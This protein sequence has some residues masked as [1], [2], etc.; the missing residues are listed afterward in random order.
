MSFRITGLAPETFVPLFTMDDAALA[1][2]GAC[3]RFADAPRGY[4]C[5]VSL[6]DAAP[7]EELVLVNYEHQPAP[8]PYR[9][10]HAIYVRRDAGSRFD[11]I[12][13]LPPVF[14]GRTLSLR[15]FDSTHMI[16]AASL[17]SG[18]DA[19]SAI[20]SLLAFR[21]ANYIHVHFA[22]FGCFAARVDR[23]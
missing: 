18:D 20:E 22:A 17:A 12:D 6:E 5:R 8:T 14:R 2:A 7:G 19:A 11:R 16:V 21:E 4:P 9:S 3:R 15:A 13:E 1:E 23:A 10:R